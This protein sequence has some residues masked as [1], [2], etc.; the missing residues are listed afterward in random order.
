MTHALARQEPL[1][2]P[3]GLQHIRAGQKRFVLARVEVRRVAF[4]APVIT[5]FAS[6]SLVVSSQRLSEMCP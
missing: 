2:E 4:F 3:K 1:E 6:A 5:N